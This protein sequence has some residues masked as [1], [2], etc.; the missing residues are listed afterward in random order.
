MSILKTGLSTEEKSI[1]KINVFNM[2]PHVLVLLLFLSYA[3]YRHSSKLKGSIL[4]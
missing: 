2:K 1:K 4:V 3:Y